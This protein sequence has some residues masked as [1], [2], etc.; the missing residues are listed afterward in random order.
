M[1]HEI[2]VGR[3]SSISRTVC[4][5][6]ALCIVSAA[7]S[8]AHASLALAAASS[9][10][11][12]GWPAEDWSTASPRDMDMDEALLAEARDY[13]LSGGGSG[14]IVRS[15]QLVFSWGDL[16][17]RHDLKSTTKSIGVTALGLAIADGL[18][19]LDD[20]AQTYLPTVGVPPESNASTGWLDDISLIQLAT[21]SAGFD[22][23]GG[24]VELLFEPGTA[25][26][27][28]DGGPNWLADVLTVAYGTD[29]YDVMQS[30]VFVPIGIDEDDLTWRRNAHRDRTIQ[31]IERREFG[32]GIRADVDAMARLGYLYMR[33]GV[34]EDRR[35]LPAAFVDSVGRP[36]SAIA[37]LPVRSQDHHMPEDGINVIAGDSVDFAGSA[38][39]A[40]DGD[41]TPALD[42]QSDLDGM[43]G[44]GGSVRSRQRGLVRVVG[45][46]DH[47]NRS[48][49]GRTA[50]C[51]RSRRR[52]RRQRRWRGESTRPRD[53]GRRSRAA[54][55]GAYGSP[56]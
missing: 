14:M 20:A 29:L 41:L 33:D 27:Y 39:D 12:A 55:N 53:L 36:V 28:S 47:R 1:H 52:R 17:L 49:A 34:W 22:K 48:I 42:W 6:V 25:W 31:G 43:I 21:H 19:G 44:L 11:S 40:E 2:P 46:R 23:P 32:S 15:G 45:C 24:F 10:S 4:A 18:V 13:A 5:A 26:S 37:G 35:I 16:S 50:S 30:R 56:S 51:R 9:G 7:P 3:T 38:T 8:S 54:P